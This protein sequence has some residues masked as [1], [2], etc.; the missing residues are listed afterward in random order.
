MHTP[1]LRTLSRLLES[2]A[3]ASAPDANRA[4]TLDRAWS[5]RGFV[6]AAGVATGLVLSGCHDDSPTAFTPA[7]RADARPRGDQR[8]AIIGAGLAGLTCAWRLRQNGVTASVFEA[9]ARLGGRCWTNRDTFGPQLAERGGELIDQGHATIRQLAQELGLVLDNVL[10]A[11]PAGTEAQ[12]WF[13]GA[14][15]AYRQAIEDLKPV[16]QPL[17]RDLVEAGFPTL[18]TQSTA[19]GRA[20]D[21]MSV[22]TW[23]ETRVPGGINS[24]IGALLDVAYNI[25][26]GAETSDQAALNLVYLLGGVGQG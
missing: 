4:H 8:V 19:A 15:Y 9:S 2:S 21:A 5:R 13:G 26:Y 16:W 14:P 24:R 17:K 23:I 6:G 22:R 7:G 10:A 25:E 11:E 18:Y 12:L 20:L 1:L 3:E